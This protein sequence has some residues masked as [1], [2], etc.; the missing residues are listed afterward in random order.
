MADLG[1]LANAAAEATVSIISAASLA[2]EAHQDGLDSLPSWKTA[3]LR[4]H[5]DTAVATVKHT[6]GICRSAVTFTLRAATHV[7]TEG[8]TADAEAAAAGR[9]ASGA[10]AVALLPAQQHA[11]RT[12]H[13][14]AVTL[15]QVPREHPAAEESGPESVVTRSVAVAIPQQ[16]G[17][18]GSGIGLPPGSITPESIDQL[19]QLGLV[20]RD[21]RTSLFV[22]Q[23]LHTTPAGRRTLDRH[24]PPPVPRLPPPPAS[25]RPHI[26]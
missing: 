17:T 11:L 20:R 6:V 15:S 16:C 10:P 9:S 23:R 25:S 7:E 18:P 19:M 5:L 13:E 4:K 2:A 1:R 14:A 8:G 22:G 24:G 12:I 21:T 26:R 3:L